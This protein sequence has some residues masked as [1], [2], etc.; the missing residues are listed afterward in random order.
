MNKFL[1]MEDPALKNN[2]VLF[3]ETTQL[4]QIVYEKFNK[5]HNREK[6]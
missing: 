1:T 6:Y 4:N 5:F 2:F 3:L